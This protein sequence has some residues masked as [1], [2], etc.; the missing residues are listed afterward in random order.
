[1]EM[2]TAF[3]AEAGFEGFSYEENI[4]NAFTGERIDDIGQ[5]ENI[6]EN[7]VFSSLD[8]QYTIIDLPDKNWNEVWESSYPPI[9]ID[10]IVTIVAPFHPFPDT[11]YR[12]LIEPKMSFGT[13]H[14]QTTRLMIRQINSLDVNNLEV[15]DM[16]CGTG[17]LGIYALIRGAASVTAIDMDVWACDNSRENFSRNGFNPDRYEIHTGDA[18]KIPDKKYSLVIANINRKTLLEDIKYY[19]FHM[20]RDAKLILSGILNP[21]RD[22]ILEEAYRNN[23]HL[24]SEYREEDWISLLFRN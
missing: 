20:T 24:I 4:L 21:D 2:L 5:L 22:A 7:P 15:L 13:G 8:I 14:H 6:I 23:L 18:Q 19:T 10:D 1:M 17:V 9:I 16:G 3:L 12:I 11:K